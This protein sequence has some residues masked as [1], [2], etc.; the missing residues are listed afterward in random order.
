MRRVLVVNPVGH[1]TWDPADLEIYRSYANPNT[2]V[3]VKSLPRGP[4]T[5]ETLE[6]YVEAERETISFVLDNYKGFDGVIVNCFLEPGVASLRKRL[7]GQVVVVGPAETSLSLAKAYGDIAII[8][9]GARAE[10]LELIKEKV[11]ALGFEKS[12]VN[13]SGI[14]IGVMDIDADKKHTVDLLITQA[15][16]VLIS[17]A[18]VI[19][20]G[21]TGLAGLAKA[22]EEEVGVPVIDPA[23][24]SIKFL[25][26]LLSR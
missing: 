20:L 16:K 6:A 1:S 10:G 23:W 17:G 18:D 4:R 11:R 26:A 22:I 25:E 5:V 21:C 12:I 19:V 2:E 8:T 24:A 3:V 13:V 14:P 15:K 9:V 7:K